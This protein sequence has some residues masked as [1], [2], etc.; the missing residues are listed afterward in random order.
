MSFIE[1]EKIFQKI[2][3]RYYVALCMFAERYLE[4]P[5][6][7]SDI[8][9]DCFVALW[10]QRGGFDGINPVKAFLYTSVRNRAINELA[11]MKTVRKYE[12]A[13]KQEAQEPFFH[14]HVIEQ[15]LY[16]ILTREIAKL[17]EQSRKVM[18]LAIQGYRTSEIAEKLQMAEGTVQTHKKL[19]YKR[20]R[21]TLKDRSIYLLYAIFPL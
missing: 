13:V 14:D 20:L 17:P 11:H 21:N 9:Q 7:A 8:V 1:N 18:M 19:A 15:E 6:A 16:R 5:E 12:D 2:F 3:D 4:N 10:Q